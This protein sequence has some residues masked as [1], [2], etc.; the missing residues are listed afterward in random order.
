MPLKGSKKLDAQH[1]EKRSGAEPHLKKRR[2]EAG[3]GQTQKVASSSSSGSNQVGSVVRWRPRTT[4]KSPS[5]VPAG[6]EG[7][8]VALLKDWR[9]RCGPISA[10][11]DARA[12]TSVKS[13]SI[14]AA[15]ETHGQLNAK[16][17]HARSSGEAKTL[18]LPV[19][20]SPVN[21]VP[22][23]GASERSHDEA[24][25]GSKKI[26]LSPAAPSRKRKQRESTP[27]QIPTAIASETKSP[28]KRPKKPP[29]EREPLLVL[30]RNTR[31]G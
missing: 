13:R 26:L 7:T 31:Q 30:G 24:D 25:E 12:H 18:E 1:S 6:Q 23:Q 22:P 29:P 9:T 19:G 4:P 14:K 28:S 17:T 20:R 3:S 21:M 5:P 10:G 8:T 16:T 27:S 11:A 15:S 2:R